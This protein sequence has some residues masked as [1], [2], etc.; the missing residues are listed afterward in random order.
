MLE[1]YVAG[2][3]IPA[4]VQISVLMGPF[5]GVSVLSKAYTTIWE[6]V[7]TARDERIR[8]KWYSTVI[9]C[10]TLAKCG[11]SFMKLDVE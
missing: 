8:L 2:H 9:S 3:A 11:S 5:M 1:R 4:V 7:S 10:K 6:L